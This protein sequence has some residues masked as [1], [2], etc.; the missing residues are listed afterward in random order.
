MPKAFDVLL[1]LVRRH[2]K[3]VTKDE[4]MASVWPDAVVEENSLNVNVSA[5]R[6]VFGEKPHEHR[7]IVTV[8]GVGYKFVAET[9]EV[10]AG[11]G[12]FVLQENMVGRGEPPALETKSEAQGKRKT[13]EI[14]GTNQGGSPLYATSAFR[15][16]FS[17]RVLFG[18]ITTSALVSLAY[19][20]WARRAE[21]PVQE[22]LKTIAVL[23]FKPLSA[24]SRDESLE[25][26]MAETLIT[27]L[28]GI[29]RL[30]VRPMSAVREYTDPSQ[31]PVNAG[32]VLQTEAVL[33]GSIQKAGDHVRV[34][35]RLADVRSGKT[36]WAEQFDENFTDIFKVQDSIAA[37][38]TE[39]LALK[40]GG[41]EERRLAKRLTSNT[42]AYQLYLQ[43][44]YLWSRRP[45]ENIEKRIEYYRRAI[46]KDPNFALAYVGLS[47]SYMQL[48]GFN[49][50]PA[51]EALPKAKDALGK[52]LKLDDTSAEAHNALAEIKYQFEYDWSGAEKEFKRAV[53]L[54]P[55]GAWGR[56]GYG[57]FLMMAGRFGE[58]LPQMEK[59]RELDPR[60]L[61]GSIGMSRL[62]YY[63]RQYDRAAE[64]LQRTLEVEPDSPITHWQ[65]GAVYVQQ[66]MYAEAVEKHHE[67]IG[68]LAGH[69]PEEVMEGK[70]VFRAAGWEGYLRNLR[71]RLE[72]KSGKGFVPP[73]ALALLYA[74]MADRDRAFAWLEKAVDE[75]DSHVISLKVEP[76]FDSL[77][78][79]PRYV[80]LLGRMNLAP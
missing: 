59:A 49:K 79:D 2:G 3:V 15:R 33:D 54:N 10:L 76:A 68:C 51:R 45:G 6:K 69:Q 60:S 31:D 12:D 1:V 71:A 66:G 32:K 38:V 7:F 43:A 4:L 13:A 42:E 62:L 19:G 18:L 55:N 41:E 72:E 53:E 58:A 75:R 11:A 5:L 48:I 21:T 14:T 57:W 65:L 16:A 52:A 30:V 78:S 63:M 35:V 28:G 50:A 56:Q 73:F 46:E 20:L 27:K 47:E 34:T 23:P 80:W 9:R 67:P 26:G 70:E 17:L 37:R 22:P 64:H 29:N 36:L 74:R 40:L 44:D 24:E 8:P 77:R 61:N 39:A 25:M